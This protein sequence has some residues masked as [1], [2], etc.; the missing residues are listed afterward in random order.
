MIYEQTKLW[1]Q[2]IK[3]M[4]QIPT[5]KFLSIL[6]MWAKLIVFKDD[7][8]CGNIWFS[9]DLFGLTG[10]LCGEWVDQKQLG[11]WLLILRFY[12]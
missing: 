6:F 5:Y 3:S 1:W 8:I 11:D 12:T 7:M 10:A 2:E 4:S 9:I